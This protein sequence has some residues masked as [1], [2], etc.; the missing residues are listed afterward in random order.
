MSKDLDLK[1]GDW[2]TFAPVRWLAEYGQGHLADKIGVIQAIS[3]PY[4]EPWL[5]VYVPALHN[6]SNDGM[7][8]IDPAGVQ[9][10]SEDQIDISGLE[11]NAPVTTLS[12]KERAALLASWERMQKLRQHLREGAIPERG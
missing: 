6:P 8:G 9:K 4:G 5:H 3:Y 1:E 7:V 11:V 2:V 10:I 12:G